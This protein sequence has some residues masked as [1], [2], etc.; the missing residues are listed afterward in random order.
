MVLLLFYMEYP[1]RA[2]RLGKESLISK[3]LQIITEKNTDG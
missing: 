3:L 2:E 1:L